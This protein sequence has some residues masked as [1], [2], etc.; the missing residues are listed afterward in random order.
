MI[1]RWVVIFFHFNISIDHFFFILH[2]FFSLYFRSLFSL[3]SQFLRCWTIS[4]SLCHRHCHSLSRWSI[5]WF[6]HCSTKYWRTTTSSATKSDRS[7]LSDLTVL[8][9]D[10]LLYE[11]RRLCR[12]GNLAPKLHSVLDNLAGCLLFLFHN[13]DHCSLFRQ[14]LVLNWVGHILSTWLSLQH[15]VR[16]NLEER[17]FSHLKRRALKLEIYGLIGNWV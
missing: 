5:E 9:L 12:K 14:D 2:Y 4:L 11:I 15:I 16:S 7:A 3:L 6:W 17:H 10:W 1:C 8:E 13:A